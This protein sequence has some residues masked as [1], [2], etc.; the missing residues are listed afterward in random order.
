MRVL[1]R[2]VRYWRLQIS[3]RR[4]CDASSDEREVPSEPSTTS[5]G[6]ARRSHVLRR[7]SAIGWYPMSMPGAMVYVKIASAAAHTKAAHNS[8]CMWRRWHHRG[9]NARSSR[10]TGLLLR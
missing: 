6:H 8:C 4:D 3:L 1:A 10:I 7:A 9:E 2:R 5:R